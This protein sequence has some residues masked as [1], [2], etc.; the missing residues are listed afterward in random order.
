MLL[1]SFYLPITLRSGGAGLPPTSS[2][3]FE[4]SY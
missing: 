1:Y 4:V 2:L 3:I